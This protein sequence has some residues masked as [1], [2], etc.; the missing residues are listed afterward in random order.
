M[1]QL[2]IFRESKFWMHP[3]TS[4]YDCSKPFCI[5]SACCL[6]NN[7]LSVFR[8]ATDIVPLLTSGRTWIS[9]QYVKLLI[10]MIGRIDAFDDPDRVDAAAATPVAVATAM[11][12]FTAA[13]VD[14]GSIPRGEAEATD[15][16]ILAFTPDAQDVAAFLDAKTA[17]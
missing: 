2:V 12:I 10:G 15:T 4:L 1:E 5:S 16:L 7:L 13:D 9:S 11:D 17:I 6:V 14:A 8:N 3:K